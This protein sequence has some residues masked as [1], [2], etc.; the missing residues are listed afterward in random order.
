MLKRLKAILGDTRGLM[1]GVAGPLRVDDWV[2]YKGKPYRI[3][4]C[5]ANDWFVLADHEG[6]TIVE[7]LPGLRRDL[8]LTKMMDAV[9]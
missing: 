2:T 1:G 3:A 8:F 4:V 6:E 5:Q 9:D 7:C